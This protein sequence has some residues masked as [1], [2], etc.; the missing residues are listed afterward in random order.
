MLNF[1]LISHYIGVQ[2][3]KFLPSDKSVMRMHVIRNN[4]KDRGLSRNHRVLSRKFQEI[5]KTKI[6]GDFQL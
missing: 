4:F 5:L 1:R 6:N 3:S 2:L